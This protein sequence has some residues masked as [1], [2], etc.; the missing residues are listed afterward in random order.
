M[1]EEGEPQGVEGLRVATWV[2]PGRDWRPVPPIT[3]MWMGSGVACQHWAVGMRM[4]ELVTVVSVRYVRH[5]AEAYVYV[6]PRRGWSDESIR[7]GG[8][9][10]VKAIPLTKIFLSQCH[11][12]HAPLA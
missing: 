5:L 11:R 7:L 12:C 6:S 3:A 1:G 4:V 10:H 9:K 2:K 8:S